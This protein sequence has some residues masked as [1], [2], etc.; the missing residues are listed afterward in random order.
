MAEQA[1]AAVS[2][3]KGAG[4]D[5]SDYDV[6]IVGASL[7]GCAAAI[8]YGRAGLRVALVEK[9]PDASAY[10]RI[11]THYVQPS[12]IASLERLELLE[13]MMRCGA[14]SSRVRM[15]TPWGWIQAS[16]RSRVPSGV[17]L[18]RERLDPLIRQTAADT[19]GV[20]LMLGQ[21]ASE[22]LHDGDAVAG[23]EVREPS[24]AS[25]KLRASLVVGADGRGS[26]VAKLAGVRARTHKHGRFAYGAYFEGPPPP[27]APDATLWLL[28]PDMVGV[29]P[30]DSDLCFY[31]CMPSFERLEEFRKDPLEALVS[32]VASAPDA[33]P[34]RECQ[35]AGPV[36]G[37]L[38][39]TNVAHTPS[40]PGLAL[41]GD[42]ALAI[43]PIWGVGCGWALQSSEWLTDSTIPA[44]QGREPLRRGLN[45]YRRLHG[46]RLRGHA[47]MIYDYS[48]ARKFNRLERS[49]FTAA[50]HDERAALTFEEFGTRTIGPARMFSSMI[51]RI[52]WLGA[53]RQL[54][55]LGG[56]G[57]SRKAPVEAERMAVEAERMQG[58]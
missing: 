44:L 55:K 29:F 56:G 42:A 49:L 52:V 41:V 5:V 15:R 47:A 32:L 18:R 28:D 26:R 13:P 7:A 30:T 46:R 4:A 48:T 25:H 21:A 33:P 6:A 38:D 16:A 23:V 40:A 34:I 39:M 1:L 24:G 27:T 37:K 3:A 9:S 45:R 51:P 53:R 10:K 22:L 54:S 2:S 35:P 19:P 8:S 57:G 11:C 36:Q 31:A 14:V 17:N 12:A 43:D 58:A 20:D 50:V